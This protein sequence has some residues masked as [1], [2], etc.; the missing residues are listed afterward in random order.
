MNPA[1]IDRSKTEFFRTNGEVFC[2]YKQQVIAFEDAPILAIDLLADA[3]ENDLKAQDGLTLMG[4]TKPIDRLKRY[5][6]CRFGALDQVADFSNDKISDKD[7]LIDCPNRFTC[8]GCG[9]VCKRKFATQ[10]DSL[11]AREVQIGYMLAKGLDTETIAKELFIEPISVR[12]TLLNTKQKLGLANNYALVNYF[13][14]N[15]IAV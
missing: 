13:T 15:N 1:L 5:A 14:Q 4:I 6:E 3:L 9:L 2:I 12:S 11:S 7:E 8:K 10:G